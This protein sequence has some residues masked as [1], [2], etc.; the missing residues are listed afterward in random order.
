MLH[1][2]CNKNIGSELMT[3]GN[4]DD[5]RP[6]Y[7]LEERAI[8]YLLNYQPL[9]EV[10]SPYLRGEPGPYLV[11]VS[12][13]GFDPCSAGCYQVYKNN[14]AGL[15]KCLEDC[16]GIQA[17]AALAE[18]LA[19]ELY[20]TLADIIWNI[21]NIDPKPRLD[22]DVLEKLVREEFAKGIK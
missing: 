4:N 5:D 9:V 16:R 3:N 21:G 8:D 13:P 7:T 2:L 20:L 12:K 10:A 1:F 19:R 17:V 18:K 22:K 14:K 11:R 6:D 15:L